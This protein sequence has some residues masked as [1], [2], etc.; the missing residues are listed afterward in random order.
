MGVDNQ[1][2]QE[3]T[4]SDTPQYNSVVDCRPAPIETC[5]QVVRIQAAALFLTGDAPS[6]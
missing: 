5:H 2:R 3:F 6:T 1:N 4:T